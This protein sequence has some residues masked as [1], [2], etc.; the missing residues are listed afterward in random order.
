MIKIPNFPYR[1]LVNPVGVK[2][3]P[4]E[5]SQFLFDEYFIDNIESISNCSNLLYE[6]MVTGFIDI[7]GFVVLR[8]LNPYRPNYEAYVFQSDFPWVISFSFQIL[9]VRYCIRNNNAVIVDIF[10]N[11]FMDRLK[12]YM[13]DKTISTSDVHLYRDRIDSYE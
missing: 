6:L 10:Y 11:L 4:T 2:I 3:T 9:F 8:E 5:L 1:Q 7:P 13:D 12:K